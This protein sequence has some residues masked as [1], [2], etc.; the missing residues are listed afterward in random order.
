MFIL[1]AIG[2]VVYTATAIVLFD[3]LVRAIARAIRRLLDLAGR[4]VAR[5]R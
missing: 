5:K 3:A 2:L 1:G 4:L